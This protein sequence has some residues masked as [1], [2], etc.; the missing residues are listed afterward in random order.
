MPNA[1]RAPKDAAPARMVRGARLGDVDRLLEIHLSAYPNPRSVE[2]RR[3]NF[4]ENPL[5]DLDDLRVMEESGAIVAHAFLFGLEAW[6][7]GRAVRAGGIASV[8]V[9]P[10]A[11]GRG[12][13]TA[14]LAALHGEAAA[15]GDAVTILFPFRQAFYARLGYAPV[16]P[17]RR[18]AVTPRAIPHAWSALGAL[19]LRSAG[20]HDRVA[21]ERAYL[22]AAA[23][24]TGW[25]TRTA[26]VWDRALLDER[27][28]WFVATRG[29]DVAGFL[30]WTVAQSEAHAE[31]TL[32]VHDLV[33]DDA[34]ARRALVGLVGAQRDQVDTALFT[35]DARDPLDRAFL[36][37]DG[38]RHGTEALEH[39]LGELAGGP[40]V[41]LVDPA[42]A[43][44]ARGYAADGAL[45]LD[46]DGARLLLEV[47]SGTPR[48]AAHGATPDLT[49]DGA[50][51]AAIAYGA[52]SAR[53]AAALGWVRVN[54]EERLARAD[55]IFALPPYFAIDEF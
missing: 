16:T 40:M 9:A 18:F 12:V 3:R 27:R 32:T 47:R 2:V 4:L 52:T 41:R 54:D 55:A 25:L 51:L 22:R 38:A 21:I 15:R 37:A 30:S 29:H 19:A 49:L 7:G 34:D 36:D 17:T 44:T 35:L 39:A 13:A 50:A 6:F 11:R 10:E 20:G 33:A 5:G 1:P 43:L 14:L 8:G 28:R 53:D 26:R 24:T 46:V 23:R 48:V 42:R 31:T 45:V